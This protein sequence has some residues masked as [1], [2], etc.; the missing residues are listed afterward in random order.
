MVTLAQKFNW[1]Q[2]LIDKQPEL[3]RRLNEAYSD[4][5][6]AVNTKVT[7]VKVEGSDP[8]ANSAFNRNFEVGDIYVRPDTDSA[9]IMTSRT[10]DTNVIWTIIT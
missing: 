1:G 8:P 7:K 9:W 5:A 6:Q 3:F 2:Q 4:T 10:D